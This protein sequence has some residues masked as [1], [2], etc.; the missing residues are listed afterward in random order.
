MEATYITLL[1]HI[2]HNAICLLVDI[3]NDNAVL[4]SLITIKTYFEQLWKLTY[5]LFYLQN[6]LNSHRIQW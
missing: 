3:K 5:M 4:M 1:C 6:V 2:T